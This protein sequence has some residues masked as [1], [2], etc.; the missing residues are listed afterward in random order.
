MNGL[1]LISYGTYGVHLLNNPAGNFSFF[2]EV[3]VVFRN[4]SW[5][6]YTEG[7]QALIS[8]LIN[9]PVEFQKKMIEGMTPGLFQDFMN[10]K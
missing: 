8:W 2:G 10:A 9:S 7:Y 4:K 1:P 6:T 5:K 3:P